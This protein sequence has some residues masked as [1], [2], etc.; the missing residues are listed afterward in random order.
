MIYFPPTS[1]TINPLLALL[2]LVAY[3]AMF[4]YACATPYVAHACAELSS[5]TEM[6]ILRHAASLEPQV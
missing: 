6:N 2:K 5:P 3:S 1:R 4:T